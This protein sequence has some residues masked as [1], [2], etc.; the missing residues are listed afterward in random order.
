[1]IAIVVANQKGGVGKSTLA[2]HLVWRAKEVGH[3]VLA[4]DLDR[5]AN[6]SE[7][8][9]AMSLGVTAAQLF[10]DEPVQIDA[11]EPGCI[12][13]IAA[14]RS[15]ADV[16]SMDV[17][18]AV[19][20]GRKLRVLSDVAD[21][22]V[23][24]TPPSL[25]RA[26]ITGLVAANTVISPLSLNQYA[27]Q[28]IAD[29]QKTIIAVKQKFNPVLTNLGVLANFI[30]SRSHGQSVILERLREQIGEA[31][32]PCTLNT[33]VSIADAID[34]KTP[35]WRQ[36]GGGAWRAGREMKKAVD[37]IFKRAI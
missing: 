36:R 37:E 17:S 25:G 34:A 7:T 20:A 22:C 9:E 29:L 8:F 19:D 33:R 28:G 10:G 26:L 4:V 14:D 27:I 11:V 30:N 13:L 24:D 23:I 18:R 35:V 32:L 15:L 12:G 1:M 6:F 21:V 16:E 3:S 5:Q 2:A 31:I